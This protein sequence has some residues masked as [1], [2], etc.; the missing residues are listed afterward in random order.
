MFSGANVKGGIM[1]LGGRGS[2][3]GVASAYAEAACVALAKPNQL[4]CEV[5][6]IETLTVCDGILYIGGKFTEYGIRETGV[7]QR[8]LGSACGTL[9]YV[10][11]AEYAEAGFM[12]NDVDF[13]ST[14]AFALT[15]C[16]NSDISCGSEKLGVSRF[17][18][19]KVIP[20]ASPSVIS[21]FTEPTEVALCDTDMP[22]EPV[23][24]VTGPGKLTEI[25]NQTVGAS[26]YFEYRIA[27]EETIEIDLTKTPSSITSTMFGD[28]TYM[29]L[30][31]STPGSFKLNPG[32][33]D[34][35][36]KFTNG[37]TTV[38]TKTLVTYRR[39]ALSAESL[40]CECDTN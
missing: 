19:S 16:Y 11:T 4:T 15:Q 23:F 26:L 12:T 35:I 36:A 39:N 20:S 6:P 33:N 17:Y 1:P 29:L 14:T 24:F 28:I 31:A 8:I 7:Y 3:W 9:K 27:Q 40:C 13:A 38:A 5:E 37:S 18:S 30:P 21:K 25:S 32:V 34:V 2:G 22:T 10:S